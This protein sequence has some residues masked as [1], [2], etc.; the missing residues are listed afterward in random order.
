MNTNQEKRDKYQEVIKDIL[1]Q[2][3]CILIKVK[4]NLLLVKV[5]G[6]IKKVVND[7]GGPVNNKSIVLITLLEFV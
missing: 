1:P 4:L 7:Y 6:G 5:D 2:K 3:L